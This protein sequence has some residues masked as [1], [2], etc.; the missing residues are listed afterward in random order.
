MFFIFYGRY[1]Y[2]GCSCCSA[3]GHEK[4]YVP[5]HCW[6]RLRTSR[7]STSDIE[8]IN[9]KFE[10]TKFVAEIVSGSL[11]RAQKECSEQEVALDEAAVFV[12][13]CKK[14]MTEA[15]RKISIF[16]NALTKEIE[17]KATRELLQGQLKLSQSDFKEAEYMFRR[18]KGEY[19]KLLGEI[20]ECKNEL[21]KIT[22]L[23][24]QTNALVFG[25][26][27]LLTEAKANSSNN[28]HQEIGYEE[29]GD[30]SLIQWGG[31]KTG[32][33]NQRP[34]QDFTATWDGEV[35]IN[36]VR[37]CGCRSQI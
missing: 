5:V 25:L 34:M 30:F 8:K 14:T 24:K 16:Q 1:N 28:R 10:K 15:L 21:E 26:S 11:E 13:Y 27:H 12:E 2:P 17:D 7:S 31:R 33:G 32:E 37:S 23:M 4:R 6:Y 35:L 3:T 19:T 29:F 20:V 22:A 36:F 18:K 9:T